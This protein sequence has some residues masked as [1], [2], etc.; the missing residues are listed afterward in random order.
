V[1]LHILRWRLLRVWI[2]LRWTA[3]PL[4]GAGEAILRLLL[5]LRML[6]TAHVGSRLLRRRWRESRAHLGWKSNVS[7]LFSSF[8]RDAR[9]ERDTSGRWE[10]VF[11]QTYMSRRRIG[12][13]GGLLRG[14]WLPMG[15]ELALAALVVREH[16]ASR[17]QRVVDVCLNKSPPRKRGAVTPS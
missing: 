4:I 14:R 1:L 12:A 13:V 5:V 17:W 16:G 7:K 15:G 3:R 6:S 10:S 8:R 11:R 9:S 2:L